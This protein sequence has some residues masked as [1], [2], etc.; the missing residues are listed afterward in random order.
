MI[1][2]I[3]AEK[4]PITSISGV[5][6]VIMIFVMDGQLLKSA[7][8]K[9]AATTCT[10]MREELQGLGTVPLFASHLITAQ[11]CL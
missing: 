5:V 1:V 9:L 8:L 2:T 6:V 11:L 10:D 4:L 7:P 3:D